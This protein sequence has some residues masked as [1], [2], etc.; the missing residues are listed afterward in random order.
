MIVDIKRITNANSRNQI[1]IGL[2][3][4]LLKETVFKPGSHVNIIYE[5]DRI[6]IV[7]EIKEVKI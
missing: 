3:P 4:E 5:K 2:N 6:I 1:F 7:K